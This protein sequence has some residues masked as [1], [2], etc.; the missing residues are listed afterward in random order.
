MATGL[1]EIYMWTLSALP[2]AQKPD[3]TPYDTTDLREIQD[4]I[5]RP[6]LRSVPGVTE[7]NSIG[8]FEKQLVV[9]PSLE[10]LGAFGLGLADVVNALERNNANVGAGMSRVETESTINCPMPG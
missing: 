7:I 9:A 1:G 5:V 2:Q 4:W 6:Q 3:G 10:R 8:G